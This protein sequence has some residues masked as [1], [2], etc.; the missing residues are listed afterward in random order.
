MGSSFDLPDI[1]SS[2]SSSSSYLYDTDS[3]G[4]GQTEYH[5]DEES[6]DD[7]DEG[8][9]EEDMGGYLLVAPPRK[10]RDPSFYPATSTARERLLLNLHGHQQEARRLVKRSREK[11]MKQLIRLCRNTNGEE[12]ELAHLQ[13]ML[14]RLRSK[15]EYMKRLGPAMLEQ[16]RSMMAKA[17]QP[18]TKRSMV[19]LK[20]MLTECLMEK[21]ILDGRGGGSAGGRKP[22]TQFLRFGRG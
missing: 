11:T 15:A 8:E 21:N 10:K 19:K 14:G 6:V 13:G 5:E 12:P 3:E 17:K 7:Q 4:L 16:K 9:D 22:T 2:S 1:S 18:S 20:R